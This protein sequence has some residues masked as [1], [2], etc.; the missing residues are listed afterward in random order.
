M[1]TFLMDEDEPGLGPRPDLVELVKSQWVD[2]PLCKFE[3][4]IMDMRRWCETNI[5]LKRTDHPIFEAEDG[6]LRPI[7]GNWSTAIRD[8]DIIHYS[9]WFRD[10]RDR[11]QFILTWL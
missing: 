6:W 1:T 11:V 8:Y 2:L 9:F 10:D 5:G 3:N 4:K 7:P